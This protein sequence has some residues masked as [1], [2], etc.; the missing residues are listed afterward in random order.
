M[1]SATYTSIKIVPLFMDHQEA[2]DFWNN[3]A[4]AWTALARAGYDLYRDYL[5]TPAFFANLPVIDG[6]NGLDVGC[7]FM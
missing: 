7:S 1:F 2:G 6:L 5:N 3:N 4:E